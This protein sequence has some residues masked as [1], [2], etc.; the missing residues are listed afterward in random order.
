MRFKVS[1]TGGN[2]RSSL[3]LG[4]MCTVLD[5]PCMGRNVLGFSELSFLNTSAPVRR[6]GLIIVNIPWGSTGTA[7]LDED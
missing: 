6:R 3:V 7:V 1:T 4:T 2:G 5:F